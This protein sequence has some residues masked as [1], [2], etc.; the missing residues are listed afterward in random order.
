MTVLELINKLS[1]LPDKTKEVVMYADHG[2]WAESV[3]C[4]Q[5]MLLQDTDLLDE[6]HLEDPKDADDM[7]PVVALM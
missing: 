1:A 4:V 6:E 2:Q 3:S 7:E 5:E